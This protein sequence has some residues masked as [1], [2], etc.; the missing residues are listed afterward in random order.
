[1][2]GPMLDADIDVR[3]AVYD[4]E[5]RRLTAFKEGDREALSL[6]LSD[7]FQ[8][9]HAH[10]LIEDKAEVLDSVAAYP[11]T[12]VPERPE[13]DVYGD[14][15]IM[16]GSVTRSAMVGGKMHEFRIFAIRIAVRQNGNWRFKHIQAT[17]IPTES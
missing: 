10:G 13:V 17:M 2:E 1:M 14:V 7:D 9:V 6:L 12:A 8:Q 16:K 11:G 5:E 3:E 15:A 4:L